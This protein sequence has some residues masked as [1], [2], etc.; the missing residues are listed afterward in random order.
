VAVSVLALTPLPAFA[1]HT[2]QIRG[3]VSLENPPANVAPNPNYDRCTASDFCSAG[4]PCYTPDFAPAFASPNCEQDELEA[5]DSARAREGVG[6]MYLPSDFNSLSGDEQLLVVIDLERVGRGL[7]PFAGIV[8]SLDS[9]AQ[10]GTQ[11][12]GQPAGTVEDPT[13]PFGF[14]ADSGAAF[15]YSCHSNGWGSGACDGSGYPGA[16]IAAGE[17]ISVLDAD[18]HWMYDDGYRGPNV[19]CTRS[20]APACWSHREN[21]LARYPTRTRFI[22]GSWD[23]PV[24]IV[25]PRRAVPVMGAGSLQPDGGGPQGDWTA[26]FASITGKM[27]AFVYSWAQALADGAGEAKG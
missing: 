22:S 16:S 3:I 27:P 4:A 19:A 14:S 7:P 11:V 18:Y 9:L 23:S 8:A 13:L 2:P 6:P 10:Q 24:S 12:S 1:A 25:S 26:I 15:A 21:I 17:L 5:I 20:T